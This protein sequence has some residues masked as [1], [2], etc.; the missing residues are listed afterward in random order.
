MKEQKGQNKQYTENG[1]CMKKICATD[2]SIP[3]LTEVGWWIYTT[4]N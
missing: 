1:I 4:T 3:L 2:F